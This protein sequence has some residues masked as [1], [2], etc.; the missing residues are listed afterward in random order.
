MKKWITLGVIMTLLLLVACQTENEEKA[1]D[2]IEDDSEE[3]LEKDLQ[4]MEEKNA[5]TI[6]FDTLLQTR[7]DEDL[8]PT[9]SYSLFEEHHDE[10]N[11]RPSLFASFGGDR[12]EIELGWFAPNAH[13]ISVSSLHEKERNNQEYQLPDTDLFNDFIS[14]DEVSSIFNDESIWQITTADLTGDSKLNIIVTAYGV[15]DDFTL[16]KIVNVYE[17]TDDEEEPFEL[18]VHFTGVHNERDPYHPIYF[19]KGQEFVHEQI[20]TEFILAFYEDDTWYVEEEDWMQA[21]TNAEPFHY[22][23]DLKPVMGPE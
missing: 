7:S 12:F 4:W 19:T 11:S 3:I 8:G 14:S 13:G 6:E 21:E 20:D 17:Y 9:I 22:G 10:F 2:P 5:D 15:V 23:D 1:L 16:Y 18:A